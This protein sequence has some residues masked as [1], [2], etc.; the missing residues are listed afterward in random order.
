M[1]NSLF[2]TPRSL[3]CSPTRRTAG[4]GYLRSHDR[5]AYHAYKL[6]SSTDNNTVRECLLKPKLNLN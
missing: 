4:T 6:Y 1:I 5:D 3:R 2:F